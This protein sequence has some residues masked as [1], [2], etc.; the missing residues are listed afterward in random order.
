M[1]LLSQKRYDDVNQLLQDNGISLDDE[2]RRWLSNTFEIIS[3]FVQNKLTTAEIFSVYDLLSDVMKNSRPDIVVYVKKEDRIRVAVGLMEELVETAGKLT[4]D[5][6]VAFAFCIMTGEC[7]QVFDEEQGVIRSGVTLF[8]SFEHI[9][10]ELLYAMS[11]D[12]D[13][14]DMKKVEFVIDER[15]GFTVETAVHTTSVRAAYTYLASLRYNGQS[16][17]FDRI[18]SFGN[19]AGQLVDGYKI[20]VEKKGLFSKKKFEVATLYINSYCQDMPKVAPKGF[21][22]I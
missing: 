13:R 2:N 21:T 14:F 22:L 16:V 11:T 7:T 9:K 19:N 5:E 6:K 10:Q 1:E 17:V 20:F 3:S 12:P 8:D 4:E 18:G 15:Y